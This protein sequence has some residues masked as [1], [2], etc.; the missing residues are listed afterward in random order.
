M[1]A[2]LRDASDAYDG[3][4]TSAAWTADGKKLVLG[5]NY[6]AAEEDVFL[7]TLDIESGQ[8]TTMPGTEGLWN[9][10][11]SPD[12]SRLLA[13]STSGVPHRAA[14]TVL[15]PATG[16]W[17]R[18]SEEYAE[19]PNWAPDNRSIVYHGMRE[20]RRFRLDSWK[21]ETIAPLDRYTDITGTLRVSIGRAEDI[22]G[23]WL[24]LDP[25]GSLLVLRNRDTRQIYEEVFTS[26]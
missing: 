20:F 25:G 3:A 2:N 24:G 14:L 9:P 17:K 7:R 18:A 10:T 23:G 12:Y 5:M 19:F 16:L 21:A 15:D 6:F 1:A 4:Q 11:S 22:G 8:V 13:L 26:R